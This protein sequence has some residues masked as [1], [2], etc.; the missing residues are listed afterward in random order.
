[1]IS[2]NHLKQAMVH[3][4][5]LDLIIKEINERANEVIKG[6][7]KILNKE[8]E[9]WDY[10]NGGYQDEIDGYFEIFQYSTFISYTGEGSFFNNY[11]DS[12]IIILIDGVEFDLSYEM[13]T[14]WLWEDYEKEVSEGRRKFLD[15]QKADNLKSQLRANVSV[16]ILFKRV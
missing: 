11:K 15:K 14:R 6:T 5:Q 8:I 13:P 16:R 4:E 9:W 2:E 1:M 12:S 10:A 3:Q 7:A